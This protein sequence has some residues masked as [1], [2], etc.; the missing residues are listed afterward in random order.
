[1]KVIVDT[2]VWSLLLRRDRKVLNAEELEVVELLQKLIESGLAQIV[3]L[4]RQELLT[5]VKSHKQFELL[6]DKLT[7]FDDLRLELDDFVEAARVTNLCI[8]AGLKFNKRMSVDLLLCASAMR[9][10]WPVFSA[11]RDFVTYQK[12]L[13]FEL[14][15]PIL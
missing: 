7:A 12:V 3:G 5:G 1:M 10:Q 11:D 2:S 15:H 14:Y 4:V 8:A 13:N 9:R 6:Q